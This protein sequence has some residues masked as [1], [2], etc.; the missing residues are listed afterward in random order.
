[1]RSSDGAWETVM[2]AED[3]AGNPETT[4]AERVQEAQEQLAKVLAR[5]EAAESAATKRQRRER[6]QRQARFCEDELERF[7]GGPV[8]AEIERFVRFVGDASPS[9]RLN[10]RPK[11]E[12]EAVASYSE[13]FLA[14]DHLAERVFLSLAE[15]F[16]AGFAFGKVF[17]LSILQNLEDEVGRGECER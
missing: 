13:A 8:F 3:D 16:E 11:S 9:F 10:P 5:A 1:M 15:A 12:A 6:R 7:K 14:D 2:Q 4:A 17:A